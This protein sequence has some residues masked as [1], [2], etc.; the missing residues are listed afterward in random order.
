MEAIQDRQARNLLA[1]NQTIKKTFKNNNLTRICICVNDLSLPCLA[2]GSDMGKEAQCSTEK[3]VRVKKRAQLVVQLSPLVTGNPAVGT[4]DHSAYPS[5][6]QWA[7]LNSNI[8]RS[9]ISLTRL[10]EKRPPVPAAIC[11][12]T[13]Q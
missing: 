3:H 8:E 11:E 2:K 6:S 5:S 12:Q 4:L 10:A 1:K 13:S 9:V 7:Q